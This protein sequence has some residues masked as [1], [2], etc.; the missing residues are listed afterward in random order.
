VAAVGMT[1]PVRR[2]GLCDARPLRR[3]FEHVADGA[4]FETR[5]RPRGE[6][7]VVGAGIRDT[8]E[9]LRGR[10]DPVL[11]ARRRCHVDLPALETTSGSRWPSLP[12]AH[13]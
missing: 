1:Q 3:A 2:H 10:L 5:A 6:Y 7:R 9:P 11:G 13:A 12:G 8:D 4:L